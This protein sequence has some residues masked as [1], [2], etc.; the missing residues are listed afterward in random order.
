MTVRVPTEQ[1]QEVSAEPLRVEVAEMPR[2]KK[3]ARR[4]ILIAVGIIV[5][6]AVVVAI[7]GTRG[8]SSAKRNG[9]RTAV[10]QRTV[11]TRSVRLHGVVEAV[12]FYSLTAPRMSGPGM[13]SLIITK[14]AK[15]GSKVKKGDLLVEFD[16]QQQIRNA[17][18]R[19]AEYKDLLEQI[20]KK[21]ADQAAAFAS[22]QTELLQAEH[23]VQAA[24]LELRK[25]EV[26]SQIDAEKN[27]QNLEEAKATYDQLKQTFQLKRRAAAAEMRI[28]E[29]QRD[30]ARSGMEYSKVNSDRMAVISPIDGVVVLNMV[31]KGG[32]MG[33][34]KEGDEVRP[35]TPFM[36]VV[37][38]VTMQVRA[39]VN[40]ADI[41]KLQKGQSARVALDA[42]PDLSFTGTVD[43]IAAEGD[44]SMS[45]M[46]RKFTVLIPISGSDAR[47]M[48]D[49]SAAV[50]VEL[51]KKDS[52]LTVPRDALIRE[53]DQYAV[54]LKNGSRSTK[55]AV[56]VSEMNDT[57]A[58]VESGL[59]EGAVVIR[60]PELAEARP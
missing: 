30:R 15:S 12:Q 18:D 6:L 45:D 47:L 8:S 1:E 46:V 33:E 25:N 60:N 11:F 23:A 13:G 9:L 59:S 57:D 37:N 3:R 50:D 51:E 53:G 36:Q 41:M 29:I 48:P 22:D 39:L 16:S 42:Y 24:T 58:V 28:L 32:Q 17:L 7:R 4:W 5:L 10:V 55:Q 21:K 38:P 34:V 54:M 52:V 14:L 56:K 31:W 40:Q 2:G 44:S 27:K 19:E 49:L 20:Q 43:S 35:G 26:V